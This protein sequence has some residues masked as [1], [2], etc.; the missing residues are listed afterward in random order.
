MTAKR[1]TGKSRRPRRTASPRMAR[2]RTRLAGARASS[3]KARSRRDLRRDRSAASQSSPARVPAHAPGAEA[4]RRGGRTRHVPTRGAASAGAAFWDRKLREDVLHLLRGRGAH[5]TFERAVA[6]MPADLQ[7]KKP[8]GA[9]YT[10]WQQLEHLRRAQ[11]DILDYIRNPSYTEGNWP[12]DYW[13]A[14]TPPSPREWDEAVRGFKADRQTLLD[15]VA[16][17]KTDLLARVLYDPK[18]PTILHEVLLVADHNAYHL[19]QLIVLRRALGAWT[20]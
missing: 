10:P 1:A 12:D 7:G 11:R 14:E 20:D 16:D 9:P 13:P 4:Q 5:V 6:A 17:S 2:R 18:G 3:P 8:A 15:L 19:G